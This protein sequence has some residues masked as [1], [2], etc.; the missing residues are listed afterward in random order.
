MFDLGIIV[1]NNLDFKLHVNNICVKA[2]QR[3]SLILRCF[4]TRNKYI[5]FRAFTMYVRPLAEFCCSVWSPYV[6]P[7][8]EYC[9]SVWSP[10]VRP[11][12]EYCCSVWS[13]YVR[14]VVEYCCSVWSPYVRPVVEYCCSVWSPYV[15][16]VVEYCCS[17]WSPNQCTLIDKLE[18]IQRNFIKKLFSLEHLTYIDRLRVLNA[19]TLEIRQLKVDLLFYYKILHKLVDLEE[20]DFFSFM[21][22]GILVAIIF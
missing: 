19:D 21:I 2:K 5:L 14:P 18:S 13:P 10:Y 12:V 9:C 16:P 8:V 4:Y 11:V 3:A 17:V 15:R 1:D 20:V 7:V 6:R 22:T